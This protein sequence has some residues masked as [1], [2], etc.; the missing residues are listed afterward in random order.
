MIY[1]YELPRLLNSYYSLNATEVFNPM[2]IALYK[3]CISVWSIDK[4]ELKLIPAYI[5]G[6]GV[7]IPDEVIQD[8]KYS[9]TCIYEGVIPLVYHIY[10]KY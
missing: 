5:A 7:E 9:G 4:G 3:N 6:T 10:L 2:H 8:Y 1:R